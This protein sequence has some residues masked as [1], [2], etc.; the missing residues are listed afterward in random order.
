MLLKRGKNNIITHAKGLIAYWGKQELGIS[1][2]L[3]GNYLGVSKQAVVYL[4]TQG[5]KI[6]K[7]N[8]YYLTF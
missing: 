4:A 7:E 6:A 2:S 5:E 8:N 1:G 3:I